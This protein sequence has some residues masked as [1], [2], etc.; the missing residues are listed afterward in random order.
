[1][2]SLITP[3]ALFSSTYLLNLVKP[4]LA[5]FDPPT[6]ILNQSRC[7]V[8]SNKLIGWKAIN[9]KRYKNTAFNCFYID[10]WGVVLYS[11]VSPVPLNHAC[12]RDDVCADQNAECRLGVCLC[13]PL[14]YENNARCGTPH[15][16]ISSPYCKN[17]HVIK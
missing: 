10:V 16:R 3:R 8:S 9:K 14:Y 15:S 2:T 1:V 11:V 7:C 17:T 13:T 12:G 6:P 5:P 4:E